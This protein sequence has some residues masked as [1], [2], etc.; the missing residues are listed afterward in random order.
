[1]EKE[2]ESLRQQ[3]AENLTTL[4]QE[5][6]RSHKC[7]TSTISH[8]G[9]LLPPQMSSDRV[10]L[11]LEL[12]ARDKEVSI[13]PCKHPRALQSMLPPMGAYTVVQYQVL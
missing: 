11:E 8:R 6:V 5:K 1:M 7:L 12:Q 9:P 10:E 13:D 2:L 3:G 4:A